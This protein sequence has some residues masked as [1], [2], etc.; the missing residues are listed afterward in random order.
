MNQRS[1]IL[2]AAASLFLLPLSASALPPD[3][4]NRCLPTTPCTILCMEA[5]YVSNCGEYGI[6]NYTQ[7]LQPSE[8]QASVQPAPVQT[9]DADLVCRAPV[10]QARG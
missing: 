7:P 9:D 1:K 3:C 5:S 6:C 10:E 2:L 8:P 4:G